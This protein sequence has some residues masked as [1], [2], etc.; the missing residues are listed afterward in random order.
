M[1]AYYNKEGLFSTPQRRHGRICDISIGSAGGNLMR[2][3]VLL[4]ATAAP[5]ADFLEDRGDFSSAH[6]TTRRHLC[7]PSHGDACP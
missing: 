5:S 3:L 4:P 6:R 7:L 2:V 1:H